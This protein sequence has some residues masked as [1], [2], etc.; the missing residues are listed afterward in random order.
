MKHLKLFTLVPILLF[1]SISTYATEYEFVAMDSSKETKLCVAAVTND[2]KKLRRL[3]SHN[4]GMRDIG[5]TV[6]KTVLCND[7][8]IA[9]FAYEYQANDTVDYLDRYT[10]R[11]YKKMR[12]SITIKDIT[13]KVNE[14]PTVI[15][16]A[17]R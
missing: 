16:I 10:P 6:A 13:A 9:N 3:I 14:K 8:I 15:M 4:Y 5:R 2:M 7:V 1:Y 17:S 12:T 11:K